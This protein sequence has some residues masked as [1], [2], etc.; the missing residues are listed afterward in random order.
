MPACARVVC[1][2]VTTATVAP[3]RSGVQAIEAPPPSHGDELMSVGCQVERDNSG[4][5]SS[6]APAATQRTCNENPAGGE[7]NLKEIM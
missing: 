3:E 5:D 4:A 1:S 7:G 2:S 6:E